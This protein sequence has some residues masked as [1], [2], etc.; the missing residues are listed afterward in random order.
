MMTTRTSDTQTEEK[1]E[2]NSIRLSRTSI[3]SARGSCLA[4]DSPASSARKQRAARTDTTELPQPI[5]C[6]SADELVSHVGEICRSLQQPV[7]TEELWE[8]RALAMRRLHALLLGGAAQHEQ[9]ARLANSD[10]A[11]PLALQLTDRRSKCIKI[12]CLAAGEV[13]A[14]LGAG[15]AE[16]ASVLLPSLLRLLR[17][18]AP[19][20]VVA[21]ADGCGQLRLRLPHRSPRP[22]HPSPPR[23]Q[24]H[25]GA[26]A[27]HSR[28][29]AAAAA[30]RRRNRPRRRGRAAR[31]LRPLPRRRA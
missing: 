14:R 12:A 27:P 7:R 22:P 26:G 10:L 9:F 1:T 18:A 2:K 24:V 25:P 4:M 30:R 6:S 20:V 5:A 11:A 16:G 21:S 3:G 8:E 19:S 13:A 17:G 15:F 31:R 23:G 28:S 29:R